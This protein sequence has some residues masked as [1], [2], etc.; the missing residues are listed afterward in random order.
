MR[1]YE[2]VCPNCDGTKIL[3][4]KASLVALVFGFGFIL[5][6]VVFSWFI[7]T[8]PLLIFGFGCLLISPFISKIPC[9]HCLDCKWLWIPK[10]VIDPNKPKKIYKK[11]KPSK[12]K[13]YEKDDNP[14]L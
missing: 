13:L 12:Y 7:I 1:E 5:F 8:I 3:K 10:K 14:M 2:E 9:F 11:R 6:G 4:E